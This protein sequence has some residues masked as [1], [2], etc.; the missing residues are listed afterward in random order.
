MSGVDDHTS[1][2]A[3]ARK[4]SRASS[5]CQHPQKIPRLGNAR[6][7]HEHWELHLDS[8]TFNILRCYQLLSRV[9]EEGTFIESAKDLHASDVDSDEGGDEDEPEGNWMPCE[10]QPLLQR[11]HECLTCRGIPIDPPPSPDA[12]S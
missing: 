4:E 7:E 5:S 6:G 12:S 1:A 9:G 3:Q 8:A 10:A 2:A 11:L